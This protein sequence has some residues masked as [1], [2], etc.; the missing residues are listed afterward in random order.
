MAINPDVH[1]D[2]SEAE[3]AAAPLRKAKKTAS[4]ELTVSGDFD[5]IRIPVL[6]E[7]LAMQYPDC[8]PKFLALDFMALCC[9]VGNDFLPHAHIVDIHKGGLDKLLAT[10]NRTWQ[11]GH[12]V[13]ES[14]T[15]DLCRWQ[16][17]LQ[18]VAEAEAENLLE[19]VGLGWGEQFPASSSKPPNEQWDGL[20]VLVTGVKRGVE[21]EDVAKEFSKSGR[22]VHAV[23]EIRNKKA[24]GAPA[25][26]VRFADPLSAVQTL[27]TTRRLAGQKLNVAWADK[28][29]R[30]FLEPPEPWEDAD[31][32]PV[33]EAQVL[34]CFE[35]WLGPKNLP[36]DVH[37][38]RHVW[39]CAERYVPL[40]V[41]LRFG[42]MQTWLQDPKKIVRILN[43]SSLL[44]VQGEGIEAR[45]R[46]KEDHSMPDG[47]EEEALSRY[48][49]AA[50]R[51]AERDAVGAT[52][53]LLPEYYTKPT[54]P[55][56]DGAPHASDFE[57]VEA[58]RSRGFIA[59]I[60]WVLGY[61]TRGCPSWSWFYPAHYPPLCA[62]LVLQ[63]NAPPEP[64][65]LG[66][67]FSPELQL[68]AVLPPQSAP[69]VPKALRCLME[70]GSSIVDL[71]PKEF[72]VDIRPGDME[73]QGVVLLPFVDEERL[74]A[75]LCALEWETTYALRPARA[76]HAEWS[77]AHITALRNAAESGPVAWDFGVDHE[78]CPGRPPTPGAQPAADTAASQG[79][80]NCD[81]VPAFQESR[82]R[83]PAVPLEASPIDQVSD[84]QCPVLEI[85]TETEREAVVETVTPESCG[86]PLAS[87]DPSLATVEAGTEISDVAVAEEVPLVQEH[88]R[89]PDPADV[90][91]DGILAT[92]PT[93]GSV[94]SAETPLG[95][96]EVVSRDDT[97]EATEES[98]FSSCTVS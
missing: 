95:E 53:L 46:A 79:R 75:A 52:R 71:Y 80:E 5:L 36:K 10:Y 60:E 66:E 22:E 87:P 4:T 7:W 56:P 35:Y 42:R 96:R 86:I 31:W 27:C 19:K 38:R 20:S 39:S 97:P 33:L 14:G 45:V 82:A 47:F 48:R 37:L 62:S 2:G 15:L 70:A 54:G 44:E 61:Y 85:S 77:P 65:I 16:P 40:S 98:I 64:L 21:R 34:E 1:V 12:L 78:L 41:F 63:L 68:L 59:G 8:D 17:V 58:Y 28:R 49:Q 26:L 91:G 13:N 88:A 83:G 29:P 57:A 11:C 94:K 43:T 72:E 18:S 69:L 9:L 76:F 73:W 6:R 74:R 93:D 89:A 92:Q 67:P 25:W 51:L 24:G 84:P 23:Y 50:L 90:S 3:V 30:D 55:M 81:N 32:V